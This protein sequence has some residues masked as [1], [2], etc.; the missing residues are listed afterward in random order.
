LAMISMNRRNNG[1]DTHGGECYAKRLTHS[2]IQ[3]E[4]IERLSVDTRAQPGGKPI[5]PASVPRNG[6]KARVGASL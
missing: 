3:E 1:G 4:R 2:K 5:E 6:K